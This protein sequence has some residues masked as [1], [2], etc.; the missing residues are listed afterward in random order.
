VAQAAPD[1]YTLLFASEST[2]FTSQ[3]LHKKLPYDPVASFTPITRVVE[4]H[5]VYVVKCDSRYQTMQ[6]LLAAAKARPGQVSYGSNG[7]GGTVHL[8][9]SAL[10]QVAGNLE[11]MHVPYRG[12]VPTLTDLMGGVI[13]LAPLPLAAVHAY[14]K[15]RRVRPLATS[16][17]SRMSLLPDVPTLT[18]LG[19]KEDTQ[20]VFALAGPAK[21]PPAVADLVARDVGAV[22][23]DRGFAGE[24][25]ALGW[26]VATDTPAE[27][28]RYLTENREKWKA[29]VK[30]ANIVPE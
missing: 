2:W 30:A 6:Q 15:D 9:M 10:A 26:S 23:K 18:E 12:A 16:A 7:P 4:A 5:Y 13:D 25:E 14:I 20:I 1:G 11:F 22:M 28:T 27:F 19:Y 21:M 3:F 17:L 29:R 24:V 8:A